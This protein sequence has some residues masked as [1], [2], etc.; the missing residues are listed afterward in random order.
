MPQRNTGSL[1]DCHS[2]R[3]YRASEL[4]V[5]ASQEEN[6]IDC[7][8]GILLTDRETR[9]IRTGI[10]IDDI[11]GLNI[12]GIENFLNRKF[13]LPGFGAVIQYTSD[14]GGINIP[15][16]FGVVDIVIRGTIA[17]REQLGHRIRHVGFIFVHNPPHAQHLRSQG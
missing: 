14:G 11:P 13:R 2:G 15:F 12:V 7:R 16:L 5:G 1:F 3:K 9:R 4:L 10:H 8:T 6:R 17:Y